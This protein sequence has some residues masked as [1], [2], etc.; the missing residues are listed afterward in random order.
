MRKEYYYVYNPEDQLY[1]CFCGYERCRKNFV[2]KPHM[3]ECYLIHYVIKGCCLLD[4]EGEKYLARAGEAFV[5]P[6]GRL[7][8][9]ND[10]GSDLSY[11]WF[12]FNGPEADVAF[13]EGLQKE[14][15]VKVPKNNNMIPLFTDCF[16]ELA[17]ERPNRYRIQGILY[18][19]LSN[20]TE[21]SLSLEE[22]TENERKNH[23]IDKAL[24]YIQH[25]YTKNLTV[26]K[27]ADYLGL[28]RT[29][30]SKLFKRKTGASPIEYIK[31]CQLDKALELIVQTNYPFQEISRLVG[32]CDQYYFTKLVKQHTGV[33]PSEYRRIHGSIPPMQDIK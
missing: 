20:L 31:N 6:P 29:Y 24:R 7:V 26:N 22:E 4:V 16:R 2:C 15:I 5:I 14:H 9:Y 25:N 27:I 30:F 10:H 28:E 33:T 12:A 19:L 32:I 13:E 18:L 11:Y 17:K 3:R 8:T 23:H 21:K 1:L